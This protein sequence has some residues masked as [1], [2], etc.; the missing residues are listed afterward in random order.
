[1]NFNDA[2]L[3]TMNRSKKWLNTKVIN[4]ELCALHTFTADKRLVFYVF[5]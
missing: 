3:P 2:L 1:M 4:L 5:I